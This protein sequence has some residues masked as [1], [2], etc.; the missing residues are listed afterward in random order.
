MKIAII[1][2]GF[3]GL[4]AAISLS[5]MGHDVEIFEQLSNPGGL[6]TG[7]KDSKWNWSL[8]HHYH[9][10]FTSD[11]HILNLAKKV[12]HKIHFYFPKTATYYGGS[13]SQLDSPISLL[14]FNKISLISRIRT[15]VGLAFLKFNPFWHPFELITAEKFIKII[16]GQESWEVIWEPLFKGK[17]G[18]YS[19]QINLA[20][21]WSRIYKRS[22]SLGYPEGGFLELAKSID[23]YAQKLNVKIHYNTTVEKISDLDSGKLRIELKDQK[24]IFDKVICTLPVNVL[25]KL[26]EKSI[27]QT[28]SYKYLGAVNLVVALKEGFFKDNTYW[29]NV[30][31]RSMPFLALVEHTNFIDSSKYNND[32][33][34]YI[35]NYLEPDHPYFKLSEKE[36]LDIFMP[37]LIKINPQM[38]HKSVRKSWIFKSYFAQ[39]IIKTN[40]S[41][42]VPKIKTNTPNL[43]LANMQQVYPWDRGTNYAVELGIKVANICVKE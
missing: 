11:L 14:K 6:A 1:G 40:Y 32:T 38:S 42:L 35:G 24:S 15:G 33:L 18:K 20:W 27:N 37:H 17:F 9:H 26:N 4:S 22:V 43:Y 39:P 28:S 19:D 30:N 23:K 16:M 41:K 25:S 10:L 8:E 21:F 7:F 31:D 13:I 34:I 2:A 29:L 12:G 36:L 3:T 5:E